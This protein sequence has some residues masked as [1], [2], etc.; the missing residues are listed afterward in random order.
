MELDLRIDRASGRDPHARRHVPGALPDTGQVGGEVLGHRLLQR[1]AADLGAVRLRVRSGQRGRAGDLGRRGSHRQRVRGSTARRAPRHRHRHREVPHDQ[2]TGR[3]RNPRR[4]L[5]GL[6]IG[7]CGALR[8]ARK[9]GC[10]G[11][12]PGAS[13]HRRAPHR[14]HPLHRKTGAVRGGG[15]V[16]ARRH[17]PQ[18]VAAGGRL[19]VAT[20]PQVDE[21]FGV[22]GRRRDDVDGG[23]GGRC[24]GLR[25]GL[26]DGDGRRQS[27]R[28]ACQRCPQSVAGYPRTALPTP[29]ALRRRGELAAPCFRGAAARGGQGH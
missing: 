19:R 5:R 9:G 29:Q 11:H 24:D 17:G 14:D 12:Q 16:D 3:L 27:E 2:R 10:N 4:G 21:E 8:S 22:P 25:Q 23:C 7:G 28:A 18:R 6:R 26:R 15:E 1:A 20:Q 13:P